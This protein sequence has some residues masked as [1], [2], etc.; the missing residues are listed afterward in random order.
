MSQPFFRPQSLAHGRSGVL[1]ASLWHIF[2]ALP[3]NFRHQQQLIFACA[4]TYYPAISTPL[5]LRIVCTLRCQRPF[6]GE[7]KQDAS[8]HHEQPIPVD[9]KYV[10]PGGLAVACSNRLVSLKK[11]KT[12]SQKGLGRE[13]PQQSHWRQS[14]LVRISVLSKILHSREI[15]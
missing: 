13:T 3:T 11:K 9:G 2:P 8:H 15:P 10:G 14:I 6:L 1:P 12:C 7:R 4:Q 5:F